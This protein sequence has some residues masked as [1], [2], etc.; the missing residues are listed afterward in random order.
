MTWR[1][2]AH[3]MEINKEHAYLMDHHGVAKDYYDM[4]AVL[5]KSHDSFRVFSIFKPL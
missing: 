3:V 5:A 2:D 4:A 1:K